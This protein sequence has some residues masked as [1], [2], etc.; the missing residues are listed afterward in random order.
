MIDH[1]QAPTGVTFSDFGFPYPKNNSTS[2]T[3]RAL[4][5]KR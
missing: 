1:G 3:D 5:A 4:T 2:R